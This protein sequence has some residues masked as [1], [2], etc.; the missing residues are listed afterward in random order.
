[1]NSK[2]QILLT[3]TL[4]FFFIQCKNSDSQDPPKKD[5]STTE[6]LNVIKE[7]VENEEK[8]VDY[9]KLGISESSVANLK[10]LAIGSIAPDFAA[11][12]Q[13]GKTFNLSSELEKGDVVLVFYRGYWCPICSR[14]LESF[15]DKL[16]EI[17]EKG[18][19]VIVVAPESSQY[20][21][22]SVVKTN[23]D[24]PY[25]SDSDNKIMS[26]YGVAFEVNDAYNKRFSKWKNM[27]LS[28]V[29]GQDKA[30]LPVPATYIISKD[31]KI[32]WV[33]FDPNYKKRST[34]QNV[35]KAL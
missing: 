4:L 23:L 2:F 12:D 35:L 9:S 6:K 33:Q 25:I 22:S 15:A 13:N 10:P 26:Q 3:A 32:K 14:H 18:A 34:V 30:I 20:I 24:I 1:M 17:K 8:D 31:R 19:S 21:D 29:N 16:G 27:T 28:E 5:V 7:K 11:K